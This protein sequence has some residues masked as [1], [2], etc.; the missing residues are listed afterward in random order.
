[1][2]LAADLVVIGVGVEPGSDLAEGAGLKVDNRI[3]VDEFART[4]DNDIV[5]A[6]DCTYHY[7]A[8]YDRYLRLESV[9][10]AVD[11]AKVAAATVCGKLAPYNSLPWFWSDQHDIKLQIAGLS[12]GFDQVIVR[13][14]PRQGWSFAAFNLLEGRL[15]AVDA[16]NRPRESMMGKQ[17]L[18]DAICP[19]PA[20][21]ADETI[22]IR[23]ALV[24]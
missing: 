2:Q 15:L 14:D 11:Q 10:N 3:V 4:T 9:Q 20:K 1:M 12:Q 18:V 8:I 6:G 13:G 7:N 19:V 22:D 21:L 16:V 23:D 5:A 24:P 17:I